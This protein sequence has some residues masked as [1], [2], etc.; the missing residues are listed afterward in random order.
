[1]R[2][3]DET[4]P[5]EPALRA[6]HV[7]LQSYLRDYPGEA[8][9]RME[10][11]PPAEVVRLLEQA[12]PKDTISILER[13]TPD[14]AAEALARLSPER[15]AQALES[16]AAGR[17]AALLARTRPEVRSERLALL[18]PQVAAELESLLSYPQGTAGG[19][20]DPRVTT[21]RP[22]ATVRH[23]LSRLRSVRDRRMSEVFLVDEDGRLSGMVSLQD[24]A[25]A[26]PG[27]LLESLT[28]GVP[29]GAQATATREQVVETMGQSRLSSVPVVDFDGRLL[30]VIRHSA[31]VAAAQQEAS[32]D[33]QTMVGASKEERA[34]SPV[35]F[36]V[37]K[38]LP[39]LQI[40][41]ATAF[42]AAAV[43]GVFEGTIARFTA[44]AVLL[45]VVAGQS[46]NTGAQ[47]LAVTMRGLALREV[48]VRHWLPVALKELRV[49]ALN[50][51]AV[52]A[53]TCAGVYL[54][55]R[56]AGL[57]LVIG[58]AMVMS[59]VMAGVAGAAIPMVLSAL[60]QD[61]AQSSSIVLTTITDIA[62]FL[63]F[64][65]LATVFASM[66]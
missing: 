11:L 17:A 58:L 9:A 3:E 62:G 6:R 13:L 48:R 10:A 4:M 46:G 32:V 43:V 21:F 40:N 35:T 65:G 41:L 57:T 49:A 31:L 2:L 33:I 22:Q 56:S 16:M 54:W 30:G 53:V 7:L 42:L 55:S 15:A 27:Q 60:G 44:L 5:A 39:W 24:L 64:L 19:I 50:G 59:M 20:M 63:S 51:L 37:R 25:V 38:R 52:A 45:P 66:L 23:A 36:A 1:M 34:L 26:S 28:R 29:P 12:L 18:K 61:P 8:A 14:I 47:A